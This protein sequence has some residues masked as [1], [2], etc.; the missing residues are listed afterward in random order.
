MTFVEQF[1]NSLLTVYFPSY[2]AAIGICR[3]GGEIVL[4]KFP[5]AELIAKVISN[6]VVSRITH[7]RNMT[8][9]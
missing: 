5:M 8:S 3:F 7:N 9:Y 2:T 4:E 1:Y 6:D